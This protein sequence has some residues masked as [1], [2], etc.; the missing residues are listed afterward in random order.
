MALMA[1]MWPNMGLSSSLQWDRWAVH[2]KR[3][4]G[5]TQAEV[6][7]VAARLAPGA[8]TGHCLPVPSMMSPTET[9]TWRVTGEVVALGWPWALGRCLSSG[10]IMDT[11]GVLRLSRELPQH[12]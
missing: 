5:H 2:S 8:G 1:A 11:D 9:G 10:F 7:C 4:G 3:T 12:G 6:V